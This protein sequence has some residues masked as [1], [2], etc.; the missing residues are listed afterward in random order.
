MKKIEYKIRTEQ[1]SRSLHLWFS[2]VA[3]CFNSAGYTVQLVLKEKIDLDWDGSKIK[4]LL[5][6]PAQQAIL[7]KRSTTELNK[8]QD[9]DRVFEHLNR[10]LGEKFGVH[11]PFPNDPD[12]APLNT[13]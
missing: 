13:K 7:G 11:I 5:W 1:Q 9:I 6:R 8:I 10:H 4:E 2:M 3:D 12:E